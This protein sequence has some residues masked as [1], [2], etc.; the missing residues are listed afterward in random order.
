MIALIGVDIE[1]F[2]IGSFKLSLID[3]VPNLGDP[4]ADSSNKGDFKNMQKEVVYRLMGRLVEQST[5]STDL[6]RQRVIKIHLRVPIATC[7]VRGEE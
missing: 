1:C 6:T 2:R 7:K 3:Y 4:I 5:R